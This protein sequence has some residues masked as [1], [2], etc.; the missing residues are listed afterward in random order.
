M[1]D[2]VRQYEGW[3]ATKPVRVKEG[4]LF[5]YYSPSAKE[6]FLAGDFNGW[7]KRATPLIKG[8][9]DVWRVIL[10]LR[11]SRSYEYKYVVDGNWLNDPNNPELNPDV[12]GGAN[13]IMYIG[14]NGDILP[15]G[16]P[17]RYKFS[18]EGRG[19]YHKSY[20]SAK[21]DQRFEF[22]Y[23]SPEYKEGKRPPVLICLNNYIKSQEIHIHARKNGYL[24]IIPS[25][26]L[27]GQYIRQGKLG[28]F[29]EL[30][31]VVKR[32]FPLD[33]DRVF[34][35]GMSYG[36]LEGLLVSMYYPDLIAASAVVF[37]PYKLRFYRDKVENLNREGLEE[38]INSLDYPYR[39]LKNLKNLPLY[40][41]H[42]GGDEAIPLEDGLVLYEIAKKLGAP[43][44]FASYPEHGHTWL[45]VDEDLPR[46]FGWFRRFKR[47]R[48]PKSIS[49]TAPNG[50][51]KN[52]IFWVD[53]F[54]FDAGNPIKIEATVYEKNRIKLDLENI[55]RIKMKLNSELLKL[56]GV[57][58]IETKSATHKISVQEDHKEI[59]L[60]F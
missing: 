32:N 13:S 3:W 55:K 1:D 54:P 24:A 6:V 21:Y 26:T 45:M 37:G 2:I 25:V 27:G 47:N 59:E 33:E 46:V 36:G 15:E 5:S 56:P 22:H 4:V 58:F 44:E 19:I 41:S 11:S 48:F 30:L 28:V 23:I 40:I 57:V 7:K 50:F 35:T 60:I 39:M 42:G 43:T 17:E 8:K 52:G 16:H 49:Y 12:A 10:G 51:F 20:L 14:A 9:D 18:L 31:E 38:F 29:P 34:V 53:F